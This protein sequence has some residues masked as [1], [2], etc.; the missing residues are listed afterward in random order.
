MNFLAG[1]EFPVGKGK[2]NLLGANIRFNWNGGVRFSPVLLE[3]SRNAGTAVRNWTQ[4]YEGQARDYLRLDLQ[5]N[6][7]RNRSKTTHEW[8]LDIQNATNR[9]NELEHYY[10]QGTGNIV[11]DTQLGFIPVLSYRVEF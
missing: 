4:A 8:R 5:F 9:A 11:S 7:R 2:N 6:Y 3:A 10:D 1:R